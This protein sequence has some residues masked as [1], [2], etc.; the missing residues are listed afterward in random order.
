MSITP[1]AVRTELDLEK[2]RQDT[3]VSNLRDGTSSL[4]RLVI[5]GVANTG[6]SFADLTGSS[7]LSASGSLYGTLVVASGM[8]TFTVT[9]YARVTVTDSGGN[10]T[11]GD[12]YIE[13]GTLT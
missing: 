9:G 2:T 8:T 7:S 5:T 13:I 12:H 3:A 6:T 11:D 4:S 10:I 1:D